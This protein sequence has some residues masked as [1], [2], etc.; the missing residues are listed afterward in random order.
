MSTI[1]F[2]LKETPHAKGEEA[3]GY[4]PIIANEGKLTAEDL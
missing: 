2:R 1:K 3:K 4:Y